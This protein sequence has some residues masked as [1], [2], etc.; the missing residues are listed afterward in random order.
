VFKVPD[1]DD[2]K[3][4]AAAVGLALDDAAAAAYLEVGVPLTEGC[5]LLEEL[6]DE[7]PGP[8]AGRDGGRAPAPEENPYNAWYRVTDIRGAAGGRLAGRTVALKDNVM[9][10]GVPMMNGTRLLEGYVAEIDATV[11]TR[12]LAAGGTIAGKAHC[13]GMCLSGG[14]HTNATGPVVNPRK[15]GHSAGGSSSGSAV[16]V[17]AG[18]VDLAIG[19]DQ[20]G[21]IRMPASFCGVVGLKPT[22]GLVPYTGILPLEPTLDH[23]GPITRTVADNALL[24]EVIAG[25]DGYDSRQCA[26]LV[27]SYTAMLVGG[28]E[29]LRIGVLREGFGLPS[30][31]PDVD[32]AVRAAAATLAALGARVA[33]V[34]V[35][36]HLLA[37]A[38]LAPLM[39]EGVLQTVLDGGGM[40]S[41]RA[42]LYVPSLA[43]HLHGWRA[44]AADL[45]AT[46]KV[47][48]VLG[49]YVRGRYGTRLY[50][51]ATNFRRRLV[52]AYEE[53]LAEVDLL[54]LP[55]TPMKATPLPAPDA[56]LAEIMQRAFEPTTNTAPFNLTHHPAIS[57]PC[58]ASDG[59]PIGMMLVGRRFEEPTIYRA[60]YAFEQAGAGAPG[61]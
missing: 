3:E 5:R 37:G 11:V 61:R 24:L 53:A 49:T 14:S 39:L 47:A 36:L 12:I 55:T 19:G 28:V 50:G 25:A 33:E 48:A 38:A 43:T 16:L 23:V 29:G 9:L 10:A 31:E 41:G 54:L 60:A 1:V 45:P 26:P 42:D 51:K 27:H 8:P 7:L 13:E 57:V 52:A 17:A 18:A 32:G 22:H 34:S 56:S 44:R 15:P 59:L 6:P 20:G 30:S 46:V 35:P 40:G 2:L 58:G 21:S 4:A